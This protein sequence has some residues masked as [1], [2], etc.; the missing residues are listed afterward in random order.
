ARS[1]RRRLW[2]WRERPQSLKLPPYTRELPTEGFDF[3]SRRFQVPLD[4]LSVDKRLGGICLRP[5][6][7]GR[8]SA[9]QIDSC[10]QVPIHL[11]KKLKQR[12]DKGQYR[13]NTDAGKRPTRISSTT[14][15]LF[16]LLSSQ[17]R[18]SEGSWNRASNWLK[19]VCS[20]KI[21]FNIAIGFPRL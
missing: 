20:V 9:R 4:C 2:R 6:G 17:L 21:I 10:L 14:G 16:R 15:G 18:V 13:D 11:S 1:L 7:I 12:D 19:A 8:Y 5:I 3:L